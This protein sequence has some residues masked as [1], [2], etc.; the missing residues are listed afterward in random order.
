MHVSLAQFLDEI[1][2]ILIK[3]DVVIVG[4]KPMCLC[5]CT[6]E[7]DRMNILLYLYVK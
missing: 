3:F 2:V 1:E 4:K 7:K 5:V 6:L